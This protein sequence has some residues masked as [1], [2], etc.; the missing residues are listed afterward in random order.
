MIEVE[1]CAPQTDAL[2]C[3]CRTTVEP[4]PDSERVFFHTSSRVQSRNLKSGSFHRM[5]EQSIRIATTYENSKFGNSAVTKPVVCAHIRVLT[6][7][8]QKGSRFNHT[9]LFLA[10]GLEKSLHV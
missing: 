9:T 7:R 1:K 5:H 4:A 3:S 6:L 8:V 10:K 2:S